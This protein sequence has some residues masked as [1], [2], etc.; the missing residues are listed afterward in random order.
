MTSSRYTPGFA[1]TGAIT[2]AATATASGVGGWIT[3]AITGFGDVVV[4][5]FWRTVELVTTQL[6]FAF[7]P[8]PAWG[9]W[10]SAEAA[11]A[12]VQ[13]ARARAF[14]DRRLQRDPYDLSAGCGLRL[15]V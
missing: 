7:S 11:F 9:S 14:R 13:A 4:F 10:S 3:S 15:A 12:G 2:A 5:T 1:L 6:S 8:P